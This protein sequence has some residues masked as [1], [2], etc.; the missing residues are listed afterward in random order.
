MR[1]LQL[2]RRVCA[3]M[4]VAE[5]GAAL[6]QWA[7]ATAQLKRLRAMMERAFSA[8]RTSVPYP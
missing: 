1:Q 8:S 6:L 7:H 4:L 5:V 2:V 3:R